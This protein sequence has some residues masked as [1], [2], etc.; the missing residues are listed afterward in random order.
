MWASG[1]V[2]GVL[3]LVLVGPELFCCAVFACGSGLHQ[4]DTD[5]IS[6]RFTYQSVTHGSQGE[7]IMTRTLDANQQIC[8][9]CNCQ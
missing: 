4:N 6:S 5:Y 1:S 7:M 9:C 3:K 8:L 2:R